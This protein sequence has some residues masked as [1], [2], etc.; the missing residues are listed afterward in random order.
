MRLC[1][2]DRHAPGPISFPTR[3]CGF[4]INAGRCCGSNK[5]RGGRRLRR[6]TGGGGIS[7]GPNPSRTAPPLKRRRASP[8]PS[9]ALRASSPPL[10]AGERGISANLT[11]RPSGITPSAAGNCHARGRREKRLCC[12]LAADRPAG[13][14]DNSPALQ[15]WGG[16]SS[17]KK[18]RQGR[19]S[20]GLV[21]TSFV[22]AGTRLVSAP[23]PARKCGAIFCR[24]PGWGGDIVQP[25]RTGET[26]GLGLLVLL[27]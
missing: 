26:P 25:G 10:G 9:P 14:T 6:G 20:R 19:Q 15:R 4:W 24:P 7:C 16:R 17:G 3:M 22:P 18:S 27:S 11:A 12:E 1:T 2:P 23:N 5:G 13:T 21:E 8:A